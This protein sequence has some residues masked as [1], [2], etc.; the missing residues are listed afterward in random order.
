MYPKQLLAPA[1]ADASLAETCAQVCGGPEYQY[2]QS[3]RDR[4]LT[5]LCPELTWYFIF[6]SYYFHLSFTFY[7]QIY[8]LF[9]FNYFML[10]PFQ[11]ELWETAESSEIY[12]NH[13]TVHKIRNDGKM[14]LLFNKLWRSVAVLYGSSEVLKTMFILRWSKRVSQLSKA[15]HNIKG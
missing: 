3:L 11:T 7:M 15:L 13:S 12:I 6:I 5:Q 1:E 4:Q 9:F 2:G 8:E 14:L 10:K